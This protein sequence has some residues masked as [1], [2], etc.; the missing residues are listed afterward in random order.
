[1]GINRLVEIALI[2][3]GAWDV[4]PLVSSVECPLGERWPLF[5]VVVGLATASSGNWRGG[6]PTMGVAPAILP[7]QLGILGLDGSS[8]WPVALIVIGAAIIGG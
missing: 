5:L 3:L 1:M 4:L 8:L 6:L 2:L 7:Y